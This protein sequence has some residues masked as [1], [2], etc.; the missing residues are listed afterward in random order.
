MARNITRRDFLN[1]A[2]LALAAG[3]TL[4]PRDLLALEAYAAP[5]RGPIGKDYYPPTLTGMRGSHDGSFEVAHALAW[6]G[7]APTDYALLDER[8]DLVV[9]GGGL[10]G[11]AAAYL[12]RQ[13]AGPGQKILI[14][15]NH[16]D[17][18]GHA[19]R[20]EFHTNGRMLLGAGGSLNLEHQN[21][22]DTVHRVLREL[23]VDL[24]KLEA[25]C[26]PGYFISDPLADL[27]YYLNAAS[28]GQDRIVQDASA[29]AWLGG[30]DH[31]PLIDSFG[32]P[33]DQ[34]QRLLALIEG[35]RDL[36]DELSLAETKRY[37]DTTSYQEFL[38]TRAGL[39]PATIALFEPMPRLIFGLATDCIS[40]TEA[41]MFGLPGLKSLGF[42]G[43]L[44]GE[45]FAFASEG[46][47]YPMFPDGNASVARLLV[48][49]LIP[50]VAP[51]S[52]MEDVVNARF[53]YS[54][55]DRPDSSTRLR[56]NSTAVKAVNVDDGVEVSYVEGGKAYTVRAG[57]CILACYN[58]I[59][60]HLC[61]ELPESQK[62]NLKY[63]VKTPFAMANVLLRSGA[64]VNASGVAQYF[65]PGSFFE[66]V[67]QAPPV[68]L[69]GYPG[70]SEGD[71]P[72]VLWMAHMPAPRNNGQQNA[73][74][75][76]RLGQHRLYT[77]PFAAFE[78]EIRNQLAAMFGPKGFDADRDIEAIT[79]NRWSHGYAYEYLGL[80]DPDWDD[81]Q[82]PHE[83]GRKP[84]GRISIANSD[85]EGSAYLHAAIDAA[86]R[87]V[88][89]LGAG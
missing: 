17:F 68:S 30:G 48:R 64:A 88:N 38:S 6:R 39:A 71:E 31:R 2:A 85:A 65:C 35:E 62:E 15:D 83:L 4:S 87:A 70:G 23:G 19:K 33:G 36:L 25:A 55:L 8:Y 41:L 66:A 21:F 37:I 84:F 11:L 80:Y 47:R 79:V 57:H 86:A 42:T 67:S 44:V 50:E 10:S 51:V 69:G 20:N 22:S 60:P 32:L 63:A 75:L 13:Q 1:G 12:Y 46:V 18:G 45:L 26:E 27:G 5:P 61:P 54:R 52:T 9:V 53:D 14:L 72:M 59:I 78:T 24:E 16:D 89:E 56:L 28:Y 43:T 29:S 82:A 34:G 77:T 73:R 3:A 7:E 76:Y 49:K 40:V 81:G 74:E 58:R